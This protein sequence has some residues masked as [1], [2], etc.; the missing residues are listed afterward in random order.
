MAFDIDLLRVMEN[1][2]RQF[3]GCSPPVDQRELKEVVGIKSTK[4]DVLRT[5][6]Q[7]E[8]KLLERTAKR[9]RNW[10]LLLA[11]VL[12]VFGIVS[13]VGIKSTIVDQAAKRL[14]E[15]SDVKRRIIEQSIEKLETATSVLD[16]AHKL[17]RDLEV[18]SARISAGM[19]SQLEEIHAMIDQVREDLRR[20]SHSV[21]KDQVK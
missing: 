15:D 4:T 8:Q 16:K 13:L 19:S 20:F 3:V 5:L 7:V 17:A 18:E 10:V 6:K 1:E 9:I 11:G 14:S 2:G 12:T 21:R